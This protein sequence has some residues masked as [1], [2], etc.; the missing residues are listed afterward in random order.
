M[1]LQAL[2]YS[3]P[4]EYDELF[5][6]EPCV[7]LAKN[8]RQIQNLVKYMLWTILFRTMCNTIMFKT[9]AFLESKAY[10]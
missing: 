9:L 3:K 1:Y 4:E 7:T 8:S 2:A 10:S 5:S 6:T